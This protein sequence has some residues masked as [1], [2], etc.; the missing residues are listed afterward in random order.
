MKINDENN[1]WSQ[2]MSNLESVVTAAM[3]MRNAGDMTEEDYQCFNEF[4]W[5][6]DEH[7]RHIGDD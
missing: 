4:F 6:L 3:A 1:R 2:L 7:A 5:N